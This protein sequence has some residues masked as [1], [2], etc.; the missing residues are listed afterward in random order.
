MRI[1]IAYPNLL[2]SPQA[3]RVSV[4]AGSRWHGRSQARQRSRPSGPHRRLRRDHMPFPA[5]T[6]AP[7]RTLVRHRLSTGSVS[8]VNADSSETE[9]I[10]Y[11]EPAVSGNCVAGFK[12]D[13]VADNDIAR[14]H[15]CGVAVPDHLDCHIVA[16]CVE[17][18]EFPAAP[19]LVEKR[20]AGGKEDRDDDPGRVQKAASLEKNE[21]M[22]ESMTA[23]SRILMM[24]PSKFSRYCF[25]SGSRS[26]GVITFA[27]Y[28]SGFLLPRGTRGRPPRHIR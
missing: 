15:E 18:V 13:Q 4:R 16:V 11:K 5:V 19:V 21:T 7:L 22:A 28:S 2:M 20:D 17:D 27:P 25:Q 1:A 6:K 8:P 3:T 26:G 9:L 12:K 24:G 14:G 23:K 10:R